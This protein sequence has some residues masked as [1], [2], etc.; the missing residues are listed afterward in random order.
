MSDYGPPICSLQNSSYGV[1]LNEVFKYT[2]NRPHTLEEH[3]NEDQHQYTRTQ[4]SGSK[5]DITLHTEELIS[6]I[7]SGILMHMGV[8]AQ[9]F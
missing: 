1:T 6:K 2:K 7:Q 5:H 4:E 8:E 9:L 3:N